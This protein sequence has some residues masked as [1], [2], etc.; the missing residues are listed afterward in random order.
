MK[1]GRLV[2]ILPIG[3]STH[4]KRAFVAESDEAAGP[5]PEYQVKWADPETGPP[6]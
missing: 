3:V 1:F 5:A 2:P 4:C 6:I